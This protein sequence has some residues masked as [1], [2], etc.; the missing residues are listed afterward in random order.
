MRREFYCL[1]AAVC[2][3]ALIGWHFRPRAVAQEAAP[4]A[5][6]Q[7]AAPIP[8]EP[9]EESPLLVEPTTPEEAFDAVLL[10]VDLARP[11]LARQ[12]LELLMSFNP[13]AE[14]LLRI[15]EEH[16]AAAFLRL[17]NIEALQPLS[18]QLLEQMNQAFRE[19]AT[20]P[21]RIEGLIDRLS[22]PPQQREV[23]VIELRGLGPIAVPALLK[24]LT[25]PDRA[26]QRDVIVYTLTRLGQQVIPPLL[27]ALD[28]PHPGVQAAAIEALGWIGGSKVAAH[29]W[30]PAFAPNVPV[31]MQTTARA[32]LARIFDTP[33]DRVRSV[34]PFD[35]AEE[36]KKLA[37]RHLRYEHE[38]RVDDQ[39]MVV[40]W[41]WLPEQQTIGSSLIPP[42]AASLFMG[43]R[44]A[45]QALS[46]APE[47][48]DI[49]A[50]YL[51]LALASDA[52]R[53]GA[54]QPLPTGPGTAYNLALSSGPEVVVRAL[55]LALENGNAASAVGALKA[56]A[57]LGSRQLVAEGTSPVIAALNFPD[58]SVQFT[59]AQ[60]VL[61]LEPETPFPESHRIV[62]ILQRGLRDGGRPTAVV[63]DPNS[64]R[65]A[66]IAAVLNQLGYE[67][68]PV[69]TG[70]AGFQLA[71]ERGDVELVAIHANTINW[72]LTPT[73]ANFRADSRTAGLPIAVY[74]ET[75]ANGR[76]ENLLSSYENITYVA[77]TTDPQALS[78]QLRPFLQ[79]LD[80]AGATRQERAQRRSAAAD[81]LAYIVQ[82]NRQD[83]FPLASAEEAL[84]S[85]VPDPS[86]ASAAL[87]TLAAIPTRTA[88][89]RLQEIASNQSL[90]AE[91]REMAA[92]QL[93]YHI[94]RF[95]LLLSDRQIVEL[96]TVWTTTTDPG[97]KTA[98]ASVMGVL[99]PSPK[100]VSQRLQ[101]FP[102]PTRP[103]PTTTAP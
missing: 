68:R 51:A 99:K 40:F 67:S 27:G 3:M 94:Q 76:L 47:D 69:Q 101:E 53:S 41:S 42:R 22:G 98:L 70:R 73:I 25:D 9:P 71:A 90:P 65:A 64:Q 77:A 91:I 60:T 92:M 55:E 93:A 17:A 39:G 52:Y 45:R 84:F 78:G 87:F 10:S 33:A 44:F 18:Q 74:G 83:L 36:L 16:G 31:G 48:P 8:P 79:S 103:A 29:L 30:Y 95:S 89:E 14:A 43:S 11:R 34:T 49:Q 15:R 82:A 23:A 13:D 100:Q 57:R 72:E 75:A 7:S 56:L 62:D 6:G 26:N 50:L 20:D 12:Y 59:A 85:A 81:W 58:F 102:L 21:S 80:S 66:N 2:L 96:K 32:A 46:L 35:A 5:A 97:L 88:Q 24:A 63:I 61:E 28:A 4:G 54:G 1:S 19:W 38:W 37:L 86:L